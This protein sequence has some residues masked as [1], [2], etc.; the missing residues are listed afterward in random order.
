MAGYG[1]LKVNA[2]HEYS[3]LNEWL[4]GGFLGLY[5]ATFNVAHYMLAEKY[6]MI[7]KIVPA[8]LNG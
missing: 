7:S 6:R 5:Y 2:G 4:N 8:K 3:Y 1:F